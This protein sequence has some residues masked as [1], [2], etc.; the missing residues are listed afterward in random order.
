M[1]HSLY[2]YYNESELTLEEVLSDY[3]DNY[4]LKKYSDD[5]ASKVIK[6]TLEAEGL[7]D[8]NGQSIK[9]RVFKDHYP[10]YDEFVKAIK[11]SLWFSLQSDRTIVLAVLA[12]ALEWDKKINR[13]FYIVDEEIFRGNILL[14]FQKYQIMENITSNQNS[15]T[16]RNISL[17]EFYE[18]EKEKKANEFANAI[19][20]FIWKTIIDIVTKYDMKRTD[21]FVKRQLTLAIDAAS[22]SGDI[23]R[24]ASNLGI[25]W[26]E[27]VDKQIDTTL[28]M[29]NSSHIS[30]Y[31]SNFG[32]SIDTIK[33]LEDY[34]LSVKSR[35]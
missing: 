8:L 25:D 27:I 11:N 4:Y 31:N 30:L 35:L 5:K 7:K 29:K 26:N 6:K 32:D 2:D 28:I 9:D 23:K 21:P 15:L 22:A 10:K 13:Y 12:A 16:N 24:I 19:R 14:V 20:W 3:V 34:N 33:F 18:A 1:I 17:H